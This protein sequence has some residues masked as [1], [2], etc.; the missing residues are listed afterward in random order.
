MI[1]DKN[2]SKYYERKT[3][4]GETYLQYDKFSGELINTFKTIK[5]IADFFEVSPSNVSRGL[6]KGVYKGFV[7]RKIENV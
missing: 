6:S 7:W 4:S 3:K 1:V 5:E 2:S